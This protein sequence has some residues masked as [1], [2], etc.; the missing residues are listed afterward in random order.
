MGGGNC[1]FGFQRFSVDFW[2]GD[3]SKQSNFSWVRWGGF[4][5][6]IVLGF[7]APKLALDES[8]WESSPSKPQL[9][10]LR[11]L[12][13]KACASTGTDGLCNG[14]ATAARISDPSSVASGLSR[15]KLVG[16][17]KYTGLGPRV[18]IIR[19]S[20]ELE[21]AQSASITKHRSDR[22]PISPSKK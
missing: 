4:L 13:S 12:T 8:R 1:Y 10:Q 11:T 19:P 7:L 20:Y 6:S 22:V 18:N 2:V 17:T 5:A 14:A 9:A 3:R 15:N 21:F 16:L